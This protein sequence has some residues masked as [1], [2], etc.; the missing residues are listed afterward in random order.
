MDEKTLR[1]MQDMLSK[2]QNEHGIEADENFEEN[3]SNLFGEVLKEIDEEMIASLKIKTVEF[4]KL[5]PDAVTPNYAFSGDSGFD[6]YSIEDVII[7]PFGRELVGTGIS[8]KFDE[9]FEVQVRPKS[10]LALKEGITVLNTPGTVDCGYL[11]EIKVIL[12]NTNS[13]SYHV[14]KGMKIA[15]GV[16]CPVMNGKFVKFSEISELGSSDR[17]D[18][19]FGSTGINK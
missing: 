8:L 13:V 16:L 14:K 12:F 17:G 19:G 3:F 9:G 11:G 10:G 1:E 2:L 18:G 7:P 6:L 15:Q 4:K 5:H